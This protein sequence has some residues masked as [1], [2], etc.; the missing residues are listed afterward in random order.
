MPGLTLEDIARQA[1]V[2]RSTVSRV[3]N[4]HPNV[5]SD[6]RK[7]VLKVIQTTGYHPNAAARTLVS[8]RSWMIGLVIPR[9]VSSFFT[10]PYFPHFTQGITQ[11]CNQNDYTLALF[12]IGSKEDEEKTFPRVARNG[13]LDGIIIQSGVMGDELVD[14]LVASN[15]PLVIAGR[16]HHQNGISYVDVDNVDAA[17]NATN[18]LIKLGYKRIATITGPAKRCETIDRRDG[19]LNA[20]KKNGIPV[21][22]NLI[23]ESDFTGAGG[24][25]AMQRLLPLRPDAV[26]ATSD[27][28]A[29]GAIRATQNAGL[30]VPEDIAFVGFDDLPTTAHS[31]IHLTT[32]RQPVVQFGVK[33]VEV[34]ID[35]IENGIKPARRLIMDT[36]LII[37]DTCGASHTK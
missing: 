8:Q 31:G 16:P 28:M 3:V 25:S 21:D 17:Y 4:E 24:Y 26:F 14:R 2:S 36:E 7:R 6:V 10:D 33:T 12:V 22:E 19:Y 30:S 27:D 37:R 13:L 32:V 35:L 9:S 34:L 23:I 29:I 11:A 18:H 20:L 5:R 15:M 1:G